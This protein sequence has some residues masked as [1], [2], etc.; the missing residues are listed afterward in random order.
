MVVSNGVRS[1][2][3]GVADVLAEGPAPDLWVVALGSND[4][5]SVRTATSTRR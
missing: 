1:G 4:I 3:E 2:L 5:A